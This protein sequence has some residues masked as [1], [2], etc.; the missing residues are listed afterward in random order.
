M[1]III[2]EFSR[3]EGVNMK[4]AKH[5]NQRSIIS[6]SSPVVSVKAVISFAFANAA[7]FFSAL[8]FYFYFF[9]PPIQMSKRCSLG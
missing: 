9:Y 2:H 1:L 4:T 5:S 3:T 7:C 8:R 6:M